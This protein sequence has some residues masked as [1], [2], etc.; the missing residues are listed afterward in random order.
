MTVDWVRHHGP[1]HLYVTSSN[2]PGYH[3]LKHVGENMTHSRSMFIGYRIS[4]V[5]SLVIIDPGSEWRDTDRQRVMR[6][7]ETWALIWCSGRDSSPKVDGPV[8]EC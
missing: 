1:C 4:F 5:V 7:L 3:S 6:D 2:V 8:D